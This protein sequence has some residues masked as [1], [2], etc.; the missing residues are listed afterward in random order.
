MRR[1][2]MRSM[3]LNSVCFKRLHAAHEYMKAARAF[4]VPVVVHELHDAARRSRCMAAS[5]CAGCKPQDA[6]SL[7]NKQHLATLTA[8]ARMARHGSS[9]RRSHTARAASWHDA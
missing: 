5:R 7:G 9:R 2:T 8:M 6:N 4:G 3:Q 1:R